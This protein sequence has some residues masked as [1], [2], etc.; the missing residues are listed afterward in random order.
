VMY[1]TSNAELCRC[2]GTLA[3]GHSQIVLEAWDINGIQKY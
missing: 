3:L 1:I 2:A